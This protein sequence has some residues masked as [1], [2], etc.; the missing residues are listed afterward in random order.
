MIQRPVDQLRPAAVLGPGPCRADQGRHRQVA[1]DRQ[2]FGRVD[3]LAPSHTISAKVLRA[4]F[5]LPARAHGH[6]HPLARRPCRGRQLPVVHA[7]LHGG[8]FRHRRH[9]LDQ[10][11]AALR[12]RHGTAA[13][14]RSEGCELHHGRGL[15]RRGARRALRPED[16]HPAVGQ[17]PVHPGRAR[18][19]ERGRHDHRAL[20]RPPAGLARH[21]HAD[22][23][24]IDF[25]VPRSG[26]PL[27]HLQL[28]RAAADSRPSPSSPAPR[29]CGRPCCRRLRRM[30][31]ELSGSASRARTNG[32]IRA[33]RSRER[34]R[35][36]PIF[37]SPVCPRPFPCGAERLRPRSRAC[38]WPNQETC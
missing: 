35:S 6:R 4:A 18:L 7:G 32:A 31:R 16:E 14:E 5:D 29:Y 2:G 26:R 37:R 13:V 20:R 11:R 25:R 9:R 21:A 27:R 22:L 19:P 1:A 38:R 8:L 28:R 30:R 17:D 15:E 23:R 33:T 10:D 36:A 24:R 3:E 12:G 34:S